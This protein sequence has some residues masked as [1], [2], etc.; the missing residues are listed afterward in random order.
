[1]LVPCRYV[2][3]ANITLGKTQSPVSYSLNLGNQMVPVGCIVFALRECAQYFFEALHSIC[4]LHR[5][6][7]PG[8]STKYTRCRPRNVPEFCCCQMVLATSAF[9]RKL[10]HNVKILKEVSQIRCFLS[11]CRSR[12]Q[13]TV[14]ILTRLLVSVFF[15]LY[16]SVTTHNHHDHLCKMI[17]NNRLLLPAEEMEVR[18]HI[19]VRRNAANPGFQG[20]T[21]KSILSQ[22]S[23]TF[24]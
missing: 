17:T 10:Q 20:R 3:K 11:R 8:V 23:F 21:H 15:L 19:P 9:L 7:Q 24:S 6:L 13:E 5:L 22:N 12:I 2:L 1:M 4:A 14:M 16:F 18:E